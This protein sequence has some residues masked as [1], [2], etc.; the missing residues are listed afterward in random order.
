MKAKVI[1]ILLISGVLMNLLIVACNKNDVTER[2]PDTDEAFSAG[3]NGTVDD[4]TSNAFGNPIPHLSSDDNDKFIVGNSFNRNS[5]VTAPAST[6]GRDGLGPLFNATACASCHVLDGRGKAPVANEDIGSMVFRLS[7]PGSLE[8]PN[9]GRQLQNHAINGVDAEGTVQITYTEIPGTYPDG[10]TYSLRKPAYLFTNLKYGDLPAGFMFSPRVAP[11]MT[12]A[13]NFDAVTDATLLSMADP[14]DTN[15]DG[16]SGRVN[17]VYD[18]IKKTMVLG[19]QGW[20]SNTASI[21]NQVADAFINDIGITSDVFP[22]QQLTGTQIALYSGLPNGGYPELQTDFYN[23]VVFYTAALAM[24]KRRKNFGDQDVLT[25]KK[26]FNTV[27]CAKCHM[28]ELKTG[29]HELVAQLSNQTIRPY[30]DLL[31]HDMGDGLAD[32]RPDGEA[33][34]SEWRTTPL[35]GLSYYQTVNKHSFLLHDGRA[36]SMEEA[37]LWHGGESAK[38][39]ENFKALHKTD[40]EKVI[41]FLKTL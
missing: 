14:D 12:G 39:I 26:I 41:K 21:P 17:H 27:G 19:R 18:N 24:P 40:R 32:N 33:T 38:V 9:Y 29:K 30:S 10:T 15:G 8:V 20:K 37:I 16:I 3:I 13:G 22:D 36:R 4:E 23:D 28:P 7:M 5:W 25:G 34:G 6:T 11:K 2:I 31:L 35:W 1:L